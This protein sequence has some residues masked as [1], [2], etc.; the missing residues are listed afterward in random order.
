MLLNLQESQLKLDNLRIRSPF[1]NPLSEECLKRWFHFLT[2]LIPLLKADRIEEAREI[3][4]HWENWNWFSTGQGKKKFLPRLET[5]SKFKLR[6][7]WFRVRHPWD[8]KR[9][10]EAEFDWVWNMEDEEDEWKG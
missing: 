4:K 2:V 3:H 5:E 1:I 6:K 8:A 7:W 10:A 9:R